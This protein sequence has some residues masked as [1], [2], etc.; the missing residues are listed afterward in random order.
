MIW[1]WTRWPIFSGSQVDAQDSVMWSASKLESVLKILSFWI[2]K[3]FFL[4]LILQIPTRLSWRAHPVLPHH[5]QQPHSLEKYRSAPGREDLIFGYTNR[6]RPSE[7]SD[8]HN[9]P[10]G[11]EF[12]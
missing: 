8:W 6:L 5:R 9:S 1:T 10:E 3:D 7:S 11:T 12:N 4:K 2:V